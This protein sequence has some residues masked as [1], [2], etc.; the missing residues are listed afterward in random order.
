M[1]LEH[2]P[3]EILPTFWINMADDKICHKGHVTKVQY[4]VQQDTCVYDNLF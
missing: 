1:Q 4:N 3:S 2:D